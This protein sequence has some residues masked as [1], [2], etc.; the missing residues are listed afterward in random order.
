MRTNRAS[1]FAI[2]TLVGIDCDQTIDLTGELQLIPGGRV[3]QRHRDVLASVLAPNLAPLPGGPQDVHRT[4]ALIW[5][6][7]QHPVYI[8]WEESS[9]PGVNMA[10][11]Y[12]VASCLTALGGVAPRRPTGGRRSSR[13]FQMGLTFV[14]LWYG[15]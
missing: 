12:D 11:L 15:R 9:S 3:P 5:R 8:S 10:D 14:L 6:F 13:F 2:V 1:A 7:E 4:A